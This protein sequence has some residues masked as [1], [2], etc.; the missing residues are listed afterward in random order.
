MRTYSRTSTDIWLDEWKSPI[1]KHVPIK[2]D[3]EF[4]DYVSKVPSIKDE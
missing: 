2:S 4:H 3:P 1:A